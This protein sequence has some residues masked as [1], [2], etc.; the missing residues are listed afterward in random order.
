MWY[1]WKL[2]KASN[3]T[4]SWVCWTTFYKLKNE[5]LCF[6]LID[7]I[8]LFI[9]FLNASVLHKPVL[10]WFVSRINS[11]INQWFNKP[12][13]YLFFSCS[14]CCWNGKPSYSSFLSNLKGSSLRDAGSERPWWHQSIK[15]YLSNDCNRQFWA[16]MA[17]FSV[18]SV[19]EYLIYWELELT[20]SPQ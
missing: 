14:H 20:S 8:F 4:L 19:S 12:C 18:L 3:W 10:P 13:Y 17:V 2:W 6:T 11:S 1:I 16:P 9:V 7:F 15:I 5:L